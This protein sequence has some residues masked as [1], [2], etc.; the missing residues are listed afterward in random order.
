MIIKKFK[1]SFNGISFAFS[2][3]IDHIAATIGI[4]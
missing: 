2:K 1:K 3:G 4:I